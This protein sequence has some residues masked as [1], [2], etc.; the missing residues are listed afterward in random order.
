MNA[1]LRKKMLAIAISCVALITAESLSAA[2]KKMTQSTAQSPTMVELSN[3]MPAANSVGLLVT[4]DVLY[5][6]VTQPGLEYVFEQTTPATSTFYKGSY[7][8]P[9]SSHWD[10]GARAGIGYV[11]PKGGW[12]LIA[13]WSYLHANQKHNTLA[14]VGGA[15]FD[16]VDE[17]EE[18]TNASS[19]FSFKLDLLDLV[20]GKSF[21]INQ[22]FS[23]RPYV[24][25]RTAWV[26]ERQ[27]VTESGGYLTIEGVN[28]TSVSFKNNFWGLGF[29][30]GMDATWKWTKDWGFY[31]DFGLNLLP[32]RFHLQGT[33]SITIGALTNPIVDFRDTSR[34]QQ[35]IVDG[36]IGV[37]WN[38]SFSQDRYNIMLHLAW[39]N[40]IFINQWRWE[41]IEF[42]PTSSGN[43][44]TMGFTFGGSFIF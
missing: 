8:S 21:F 13:T 22:G 29:R 20:V 30:G 25:L 14:P 1:C 43:L 16:N 19:Q 36:S 2:E 9:N 39:E 23:L 6:N 40:H 41:G 42:S 15:L 17:Y 33:Q 5:W 11:S 10:V 38:K 12:D 7:K 4:A 28:F 31:G 44:A 37:K 26:K 34:T 32:G 27:Q 18:I 24:G 35:L 3:V